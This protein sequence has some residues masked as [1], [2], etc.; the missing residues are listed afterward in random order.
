[1]STQEIDQQTSTEKEPQEEMP[2]PVLHAFQQMKNRLH[3]PMSMWLAIVEV[4]W[5]ALLIGMGVYGEKTMR[6]SA[7][8]LADLFF[9]DLRG[10]LPAFS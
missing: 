1:M 3:R 5:F 2:V 10:L 8:T 6:L 9:M 4:L 7:N